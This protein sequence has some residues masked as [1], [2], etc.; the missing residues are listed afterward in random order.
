MD[1]LPWARFH[2]LVIVSLGITWVLDGL[3]VTIVGA[4]S[5][6]LGNP[7]TLGLSPAQI[8]LLASWYL[9]GAVAGALVFGW[10]TDRFGR[11]KL[12]FVTL[13]IYLCGVLL[14]AL[15]WNLWSFCL[16]RFLTGAGIGGEYSAINSAIDELIPARLRGRVD[17]M[18]NGSYWLGAAAGSLSTIVILNPRLLPINVGWRL[19]FAAGGVLG[20]IVLF[21]RRFVP[22]SPRWL[23]THG[24]ADEAERAASEIEARVQEF[25]GEPLPHPEGPA[26][27]IRA[28]QVYGFGMIAVAMFREHRRRAILGLALMISQAFFYNSLFFTYALVLTKFYGIDPGRTGLYLLPF[29]L[30]NFLG[31]MAL[32]HLFDT[33]GRRIMISATYG[34]SALLLAV[35]AFLFVRN[36]ISAEG[37]T[38]LWTVIFFFASPAASS[39]Y[40]TVSEIFPLET[41]GLAIAFFYAAGTGIGGIVA[42]WLFGSL[43]AS[44]SRANLFYGYL[45]SAVL[46]LGA[47]IIE[48]VCGVKAE[49]Q[50]LEALA[51]PL[52]AE[53]S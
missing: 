6:V 44:G 45:A 51:R 13:I 32:G 8:G 20:L 26:L 10:A 19:G 25:T 1:R 31:P 33:I 12:F 41:R 46:M 27:R 47:A 43:I 34:V 48:T 36:A 4:I 50:G 53:A 14:S 5:G 7:H 11:R 49:G 17:L 21:L 40:L 35:T 16:F 30:G 2:W 24:H 38:I 3:E 52:S 23:L 42:P 18:V 22:E 39:A 28:Q 9:A 29:A 37:Q 15:A